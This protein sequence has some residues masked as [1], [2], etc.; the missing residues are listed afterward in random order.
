M[1]I[2]RKQ[3]RTTTNRGILPQTIESLAVPFVLA[4]NNHTA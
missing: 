1:I 3:D 4:L 2:N